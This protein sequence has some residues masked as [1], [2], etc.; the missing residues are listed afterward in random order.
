MG[1]SHQCCNQDQSRP[2]KEPLFLCVV[3]MRLSIV[4]PAPGTRA[5]AGTAA[6][7]CWQIPADFPSDFPAGQ[8]IFGAE[9]PTKS[10][11]PYHRVLTFQSWT[12]SRP[13]Y[14]GGNGQIAD[15]VTAP[16]PRSEL[17][18]A[19]PSY[20]IWWVTSSHRHPRRDPGSNSR[21]KW[22][23]SSHRRK[24][25]HGPRPAGVSALAPP[26]KPR[27]CSPPARTSAC[28]NPRQYTAFLPR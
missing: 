11:P 25:V 7:L 21:P 28:T 20:K 16:I 8:G 19:I 14:H 12:K 3:F 2:H 15:E 17:P 18:A 26:P 13:P 22:T 23:P 6:P 1:T 10:R 4:S 5:L 9:S 27:T 24:P